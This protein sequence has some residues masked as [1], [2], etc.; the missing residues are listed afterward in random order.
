MKKY[1]IFK[2]VNGQQPK[3]Y[4]QV[5][6]HNFEA[7]QQDLRSM[8]YYTFANDDNHSYLDEPLEG[9]YFTEP[10]IYY[11]GNGELLYSNTEIYS[12]DF[13]KYGYG[14]W[15]EYIDEVEVSEWPTPPKK[16]LI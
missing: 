12:P 15:F 16:S 14:N 13:Y 3:A 4:K 7:A 11:C 9:Y 1:Q 10:G 2:H 5:L 8:C 6:Y